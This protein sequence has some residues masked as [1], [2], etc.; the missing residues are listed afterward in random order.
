MTSG[1]ALLCCLALA[2]VGV[3]LLTGEREQVGARDRSERPR[4]QATQGRRR[5]SRDAARTGPV[6][7][8]DT[9]PVNGPSFA[10]VRLRRGQ[11]APL[12]AAPN[13]R[14]IRTVGPRT[15]FGSEIVLGVVKRRPGWLGVLTAKLAEPQVG[16]LRL[17]PA[18]MS[19]YWTKYSIG[20]DLSRLR[21]ELRYGSRQVAGFSG[22]DRGAGPRDPGR[23][24]CR[25]RR[26][27][28]RPEPLLRLLRAGA[29]RPP[30]E[31][32]AGLAGRRPDRDPRH[33]RPGRR[34]C[35][36]RLPAGHRRRRCASFSTACRWGRRSSSGSSGLLGQRALEGFGQQGSRSA[37]A[38]RSP[39]SPKK[40][41]P[42]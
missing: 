13:G 31:P 3:L 19:V 41:P 8:L 29:E 42:S 35:L 40:T 10:I 17:D 22:L 39:T 23:P 18:R 11:S 2:A 14:V 34:G 6:P 25:H 1:V 7:S 26:D 30:A 37:S 28:L 36:E 27:Q 20:V 38:S 4:A 9:K 32:A 15:E 21:L 33:P 12:H 24:L 5:P 16:W